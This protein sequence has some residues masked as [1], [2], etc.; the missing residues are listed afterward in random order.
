VSGFLWSGQ[1]LKSFFSTLILGDRKGSRCVENQYLSH[2][3]SSDEI[4]QYNRRRLANSGPSGTCTCVCM[5]PCDVIGE[6][7]RMME[8]LS[9]TCVCV[10]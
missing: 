7:D 1:D 5:C 6:G 4:E 9:G 8:C 3:F 2:R 10:V